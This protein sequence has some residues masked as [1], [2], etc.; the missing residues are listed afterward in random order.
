MKDKQMAI[1]FDDNIQMVDLQTQY[2]RLKH[3]ID[4][5]IQEVLAGAQFINGPQVKAF[6]THLAQYLDIPHVIPCANGT[7]ALQIALMSLNL[8]QGEEVIVPAFNYVAAAETVAMLGLTPV[9]VDVT[10]DTFTMDVSKI[11][12][13]ISRHTKVIIP[14]HLFGLACDMG[15]VMRIAEK[16]NLYVIEDNA[17]SMGATY[18]HPSGRTKHAGTIGHISTT[19]FF[20][21]KPLACYG[22]GG[23]MMTADD[24]LA[25]RLYMIANHGQEKKYRHKII[26]C[27][28]RLD[29]LQ[30]AILHV[31]LNHLTEFN[32]ARMQVAERYNEAFSQLPDVVTPYKPA[33][34]SHIY[35][36][37]TIQVKNGK[38]NALQAWLKER[39][40]P[41]TIYYPTSLDKQEAFRVYARK[42]GSLEVAGRLTQ[43]VLSLPIHTEMRAYEQE[44]I[45]GQVMDFFKKNER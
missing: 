40:V 6:A 36:Q 1:I 7:D 32:Q 30:A 24:T 39:K 15:A 10:A 13:A 26:G 8:P 14:V 5:A 20:P 45:I 21:S 19:S 29:T 44:Y 11:E 2:R 38:R 23:A 35:H 34:T 41:S 33:Y 9:L 25:K 27:N 42:A 3:E 43:T 16:Y 18:T 4:A 17:Q 37:Y 28:S 31:K 22:D 12:Q